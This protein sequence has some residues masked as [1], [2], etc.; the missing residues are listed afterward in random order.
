MRK[1]I[2]SQLM[3]LAFVMTMFIAIGMAYVMFNT[4]A[5]VEYDTARVVSS[6]TS[7]GVVVFTACFLIVGLFKD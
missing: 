6:I 3:M 1:M 2:V 4:A 5:T 7:T